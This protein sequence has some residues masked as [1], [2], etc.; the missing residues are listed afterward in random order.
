MYTS[1][2][3]TDKKPNDFESKK[4]SVSTESGDTLVMKKEFNVANIANGDVKLSF[5]CNKTTVTLKTSKK[6]ES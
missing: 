3:A 1:Y 4:P 6:T 5:I 2:P